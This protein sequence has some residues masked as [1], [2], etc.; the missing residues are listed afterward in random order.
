MKS[1][2]AAKGSVQAASDS[3]KNA[4][5]ATSNLDLNNSGRMIPP[6]EDGRKRLANSFLI[7]RSR[8]I[9]D[10]EQ[11]RQKFDQ[12]EM[13]ELI[14]SIKERGVKQPLTVRWNPTAQKYMVIDGG[15]RHEAATQLKLEELPCWVQEGDRKE[16]LIDQI[17][18]NWQRV[19]LRP[20]ETADALA[21]L[22]DSHGLTQTELVRVT[23]KPKGEISK[24][25]ALHD[26]VDPE[27][28]AIARNDSDSPLTKR[29]LYNISKLKPDKQ[30]E[31]AAKVQE[32]Q[33][34]A[35]QTEQLI[36]AGSHKMNVQK[37]PG[38]AARQRRFKTANADVVITFRRKAI[39]DDDV[40]D[41]IAELARL[42]V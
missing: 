1:K 26:K 5:A 15:R 16:V 14:A 38:I 42:V 35:K 37:Q 18:H 32:E 30:K 20:Y 13:L 3:A 9:P 8:I 6:E 40:R 2:P 21:R 12:M 23:G 7:Q 10:P 34:T 24:L 31:I 22:R 33:L 39:T 41:V 19:D 11:P 25:L 29:H 28:Q 27:V 4:F 36:N 17:V